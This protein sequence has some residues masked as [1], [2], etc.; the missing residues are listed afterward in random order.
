MPLELVQQFFPDITPR[1]QAQ[2]EHLALLFREWNDKINLVSRK[3]IDQW[4]EH[5]LLHSL[6]LAKVAQWPERARVLDVGTGGGLPGLPLA[7]LFPEVQF[8]LCDS[9]AKK[10]QAVA[11]MAERL[12]LKNVQAVNKRAEQLESKWEFV[13]GRA[14]TA[15]PN[16][17]PWVVDNIRP[18]GVEGFPNGV[19][20]LKGSL[21]K[22][23]LE[24]LGV[25][26]YAVY[27]LHTLFP[28][29]YFQEKYLVHLDTATLAK[30]VQ[31]WEDPQEVARKAKRAAK[32]AR[33]QGRP[34]RR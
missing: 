19:L 33:K 29:D 31:P 11:D 21:Y 30:Q 7:I 8:F 32:T 24:A 17:L 26:P 1:Q 14:V 27:D 15:L 34:P 12:K 9:V 18:G 10:I 16:F 4:E 5:H 6:A 13:T 2:L 28:R 3:D 20:Y 23:E 22:D 25:E